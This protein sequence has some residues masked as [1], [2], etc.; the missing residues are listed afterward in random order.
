MF[1]F[2]LLLRVFPYVIFFRENSHGGCARIVE[3]SASD[4]PDEPGNRA[5]RQSETG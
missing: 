4:R 2:L 1:S 3:L 5:E